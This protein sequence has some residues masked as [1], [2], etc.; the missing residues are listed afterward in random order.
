MSNNKIIEGFDSRISTAGTYRTSLILNADT[1]EAELQK[2][3]TTLTA[4]GY[5]VYPALYTNK[6]LTGWKSSYTDAA[7]QIVEQLHEAGIDV[8]A[9]SAEL[10]QRNKPKLEPILQDQ[11]TYAIKVELPGNQPIK[12]TPD[13]PNAVHAE[14]NNLLTSGN[15]VDTQAVQA[16]DNPA[17]R[18]ADGGQGAAGGP[19]DR[20]GLPYR[21][22]AGDQAADR[23]QGCL[24]RR[25]GACR[26]CRRLRHRG[27][28][29]G[30]YEVIGRLGRA[31]VG[32]R[33]VAQ[34]GATDRV[35][36]AGIGRAQIQ[37]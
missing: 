1:S 12:G 8:D 14:L 29:V 27:R 33:L 7:G 31:V 2:L 37:R 36:N 34:D 30:G 9:L 20:R 3:V 23:G 4:N 19:E 6:A 25:Q 16:R 22:R 26:L 21:R 28:H 10:K 17:R 11:P 24:R 15:F 32:R 35:G 13:N 5:N 18:R